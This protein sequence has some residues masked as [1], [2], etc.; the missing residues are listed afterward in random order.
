MMIQWVLAELVLTSLTLSHLG[1]C[2][3]RAELEADLY[4]TLLCQGLAAGCRG[5]GSEELGPKWTALSSPLYLAVPQGF[6]ASC[7]SP[8]KARISFAPSIVHLI[9]RTIFLW[10]SFLLVLQPLFLPCRFYFSHVSP[11]PICLAISQLPFCPCV[12]IYYLCT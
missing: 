8:T 11:C 4:S 6:Y 3:T 5:H 7:P 9:F 1:R 2:S 10:T 12:V